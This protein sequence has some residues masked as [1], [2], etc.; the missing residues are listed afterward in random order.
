MKQTTV[1][2]FVGKLPE[3]WPEKAPKTNG[4]MLGW[5]IEQRVSN[6]LTRFLRWF[7]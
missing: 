1:V 5:L 2:R 6:W 7:R 4:E 3:G